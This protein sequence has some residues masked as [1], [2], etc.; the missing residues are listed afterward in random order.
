MNAIAAGW[1]FLVANPGITATILAADVL[2]LV[3]LARFRP[4]A[5]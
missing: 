5:G 2:L 1:E 4:A 3:A